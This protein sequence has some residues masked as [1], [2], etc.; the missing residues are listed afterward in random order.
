MKRTLAAYA[1]TLIL[2]VA[3]DLLWLGLIAKPLYL[4]GIGHLMAEEP[5]VAVAIV[6]YV[7]YAGGLLYF[8][9]LARGASPDWWPTLRDAALFG[10]FAYATYDL[11][12]LATLRDWPVGLA[13]IDI[14]WGVFVS[15]TSAVA[16]R[17]V[18]VRVKRAG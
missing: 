12:N 2:M 11:T 7:V 10:F 1:A 14:A 18:W 5:D 13:M 17:A 6:F 4:Q 16:G 9:V 15:A 3:L 8:S